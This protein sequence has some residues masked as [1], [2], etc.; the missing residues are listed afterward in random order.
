MTLKRRNLSIFK[1]LSMPVSYKILDEDKLYDARNVFD[2]KGITET[3]NG[4]RRYNASGIGTTTNLLTFPID[5]DNAA[6]VKSNTAVTANAV[7]APDGNMT[8]DFV[9]ASGV[10]ASG[11]SIRISSTPL[12]VNQVNTFS[13]YAKAGTLNF[14]SLQL[15]NAAILT[16]NILAEFNLTNGTISV[17]VINSGTATD[18]SASIEAVGDGWYLCKISGITDVTGTDVRTGIGIREVSG[19]TSVTAGLG[20]YIWGA[21]LAGLDSLS[22]Y[23]DPGEPVISIT[24]FKKSNGTRYKI[25]KA[26]TVLY[27][28]SAVGAHTAIKTSLSPGAKHRA[29]TIGDRHIIAVE[30]DGLFSFDGTTFTQLGQEAPTTL[31]AAAAAGGS[32]TTSSAYRAAVTFYAS[33]IG[34]ETNAFSAQDVTVSG[35][36]LRLALSNIPLTAANALID[37]VRIYLKDVT[38]NSA[39]LFVAEIDL[40]I[41][42]YN[43]DTESIST[44]IPP[45]T[46]AAPIAGGAKYLALFGKKVAY[47]GNGVFKNDVFISEEYLPDAF[48]DTETASTLEIPGQGENTGIACGLYDNSY[49]NPYLAIFKKT[50]ITIYSELNGNPT[51]VTIDDHVGCVS[52]DTIK[53]RNGDIGF[54]SEN[55]WYVIHNGS[56]IKK[57]GMPKPLGDGDIDDIFSREGWSNQLNASQFSNFFSAYYSTLGHYMTFVAEAGNGS[58][59]KAYN[60]EERIGGFRVY[61]FKMALTCA[62]EGE[63]DG[64][65]QC[66]F[67][68]S[69]KGF[70]YTLSVKNSRVDDAQSYVPQS[71]PTI[72]YLPFI[73]PGD[74]SVTYNWRALVL[75]AIQSTDDFTVSAYPS[76]SLL[77]SESISYDFS[78]EASGF[79]L[80]LSQL[81]VDSLGDERVPVVYAADLNRTGEVMIIK[82]S[83]DVLN[84]NIGLISCQINYNKNGNRN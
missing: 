26:G 59:L 80:D 60:F 84:A 32:L 18:G 45:T 57:D 71:I 42:T 35:A 76:Y 21:H 4:L 10:T 74:D 51:Q 44:Q 6:W 46:N 67:L 61:D 69:T 49:L 22:A 2:N 27:S 13:V 36:N 28:V 81:D 68:G 30:S 33:S 24:Y 53:V 83:Q 12:I 75:K 55:G 7:L 73:V 64:G 31:T 56:L 77:T 39:M 14:L 15:S 3:R 37:K 8:A 1:K 5:F 82:F 62:C 72:V 17:A 16:N 58:F 52:H 79:I 34:F 23:P 20:A 19:T 54:M 65:N 9:N 41:T 50:S 25:V 48:N 11:R 43:I 47:T 63:D 66:I 40:G 70:I 38:A 29:I 78:N